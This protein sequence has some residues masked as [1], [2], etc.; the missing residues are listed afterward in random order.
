MKSPAM[1]ILVFILALIGILMLPWWISTVVLIALTIYFP[2][3]LEVLF[4]GFLFDILYASREHFPFFA[5]SLAAIFL[6]IVSFV[7]SRIRV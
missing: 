5:L 1:R 4:F 2:F 7:R 3:Y 6:I